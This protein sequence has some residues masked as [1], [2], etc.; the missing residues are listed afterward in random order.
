MTRNE[1]QGYRVYDTQGIS[2]TIAS[3]A[4][5][6]GAKTGLYAV[7]SANKRGYEIAENGDSV[8]LSHIGSKTGRGRVGK[9]QSQTLMLSG[10]MFTVQ[11][12]K[13]R[14]LM[15]IECERLMGLPDNWTQKGIAAKEYELSDSARYK[16][17]GNGVVVNV[18]KEII[19]SLREEI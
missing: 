2:T 6:L 1:S 17:C 18:V 10:D 7:P 19:L 11:D 5:G 15:P 13:V 3:Q 14:R 4:G 16:L 12:Y 8:R 9:K